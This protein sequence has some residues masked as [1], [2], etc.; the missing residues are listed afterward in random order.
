VTFN[1]HT[2]LVFIQATQPSHPSVGMCDEYWRCFRPQPGEG[3]NDE[4]CVAVGCMYVSLIWSNP[5]R[6]KG[7]TPLATDFTVYE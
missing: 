4:F 6:L 3:R 5:R 2:I 7:M 1:R